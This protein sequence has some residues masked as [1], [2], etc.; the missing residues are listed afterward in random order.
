MNGN[1]YF[2]NK[3][4]NPKHPKSSV[5]S[6]CDALWKKL[7]KR[8][9]FRFDFGKNNAFAPYSPILF[10][11][12]RETVSEA[13]DCSI[14]TL[15]KNVPDVCNNICHFKISKNQLRQAIKKPNRNSVNEMKLYLAASS[16]NPSLF[17]P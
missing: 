1:S 2:C 5:H 11:V 17:C 13:R 3:N 6:I 12:A 8:I 15:K 9:F 16:S 7:S 10:G 4:T 14:A